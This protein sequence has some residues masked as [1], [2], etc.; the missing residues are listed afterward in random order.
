ME[1]TSFFTYL[2]KALWFFLPAAFANFSPMLVKKKK[3][4]QT[5]I[6]FGKTLINKRVIGKN[7]TYGGLL[8]GLAAAVIVTYVQ[9]LLYPIMPNFYLA[10]YTKLNFLILGLCL[11]F[12]ALTGDLIKSF[13][14]RRLNK[15]EGINW[16]PFDQIDW[17]IGSI[18]VA[19]IYIDLP[20]RI[21]IIGIVFFGILDP[22]ISYISFR[23]K[24]RKKNIRTKMKKQL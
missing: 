2:V 7:K 3:F 12:G 22:S 15:K 5:P 23:I 17:I 14:K 21:G 13:I 11:G 10:D 16:I 19:M 24:K 20:L 9:T 1:I 8:I 4:I 6:D 18:I